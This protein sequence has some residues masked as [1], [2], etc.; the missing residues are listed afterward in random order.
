M[1]L[2]QTLDQPDDKTLRLE[3]LVE[4]TQRAVLEG[5]EGVL[6][7]QMVPFLDHS[8]QAILATIDEA[9]KIHGD[10]LRARLKRLALDTAEE[11]LQQR[12]EPLLERTRHLLVQGL[13]NAAV[14]QKY[15]DR[16]TSALK[17]V[18]REAIGEVF[19]V[20][21]PAYSGRVGRRVLDY[22]VA[23]T[24]F[25]VTAVFLLM[26]LVLGLREAGL[27]PYATYLVGGGAAGAAGVALLTLRHPFRGGPAG[28][29]ANAG[30]L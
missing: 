8:R 30:P 12:L 4:S 22:V 6:Q 25:C 13:E 7:R 24:L 19:Q 14:V 10:S 3:R 18:T 23:G 28:P 1:T 26:A 29:G 17:Q 15:T 2:P 20:Q 27:P 11:L 9:V 5:V 16:L 21:L